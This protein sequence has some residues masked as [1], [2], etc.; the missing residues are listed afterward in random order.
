MNRDRTGAR[1]AQEAIRTLGHLAGEQAGTED[2]P[3]CRARERLGQV[4][5]ETWERLSIAAGGLVQALLE[6][7]DPVPEEPPGPEGRSRPGKPE[8]PGEPVDVREPDGRP[9]GRR[10]P[11]AQEIDITD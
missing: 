3:L 2:C 5:P 4:Q 9:R 8:D 11:R 10:P 7:L 1:I 6:V